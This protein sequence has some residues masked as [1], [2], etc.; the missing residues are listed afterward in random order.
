MSLQR[1]YTFKIHPNKEQAAVMLEQ[2]SMVAGLWNILLAMQEYRYSRVRGQ[3]GVCHRPDEKAM[4]SFFDL[5][6]EITQMRQ[7]LDEWSSLSVWTPHRVAD[8]LIKSFEAFFR[9]A[10]QGAGKSSGYPKFK[11]YFRGD[12][13]WLPHRFASGCKMTHVKGTTWNLY[14]KGV[15]GPVFCKGKLPCDPEKLTHA[16]IRYKSG[17]WW[18]SVGTAMPENRRLAGNEELTIRLDLLDYFAKVNDQVVT[19]FDVGLA[20]DSAETIANLQQQMVK[21]D[22]RG[23]EYKALKKRKARI[24]AKAARQRKN[25]LHVWTTKLVARAKRI[26]LVV[27]ADIKESTKSGKGDKRQWGAA[28]ALKAAINKQILEQAPAMVIQML[29]Y[30]AEEAGVQLHEITHHDLSVGQYVVDNR[31]AAR[32]VSRELK[33]ASG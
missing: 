18:F 3:K 24:E 15:D 6:Y 29:K 27:P 1:R 12:H 25:A 10:K 31:K 30:K 8:A 22:R 19:R 5:T 33:K 11:S 16:D 28:V 20:Q 7:T 21:L 23:D 17:T 14:L 2:C 32:K 26:T 13:N 4:S 9:R